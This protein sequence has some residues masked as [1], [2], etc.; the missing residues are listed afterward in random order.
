[1]TSTSWSTTKLTIAD[2]CNAFDSTKKPGKSNKKKVVEA[3]S[4]PSAEDPRIS[5]EAIEKM[6]EKGMSTIETAIIENK[7]IDDA[8]FRKVVYL[9]LFGPGSKRNVQEL[10]QKVSSV[11]AQIEETDQKIAEHDKSLDKIDKKVA[12][13]EIESYSN[14]FLLKN[15]PLRATQGGKEKI[16]DTQKNSEEILHCADLDLT[17]VDEFFRLYPSKEKAL[18]QKNE[19]K[20]PN[21]FVKFSSKRHTFQFIERLGEIKK[22]QDFNDIQLE[23]M[24]PPCLI[25]KWNSA[26]KQAYKLRKEKKLKTKT[27]IR[28]DEVVLLVKNKGDPNF[29]QVQFD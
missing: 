17:V 8:E 7:P 20:V 27:D 21:I 25:D 11:E 2:A 14:K 3:S 12:S 4:A 6:L 29:T 26:N 23:K 22:K 16:L 9:A 15:V 18:R 10:Y 19:G 5:S 1:M 28:N 13:L 24:V